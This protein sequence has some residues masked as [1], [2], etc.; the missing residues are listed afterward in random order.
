MLGYCPESHDKGRDEV[1]CLV[2]HV[3]VIGGCQ[4]SINENRDDWGLARI[5]AQMPFCLPNRTKS[6]E[7]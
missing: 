2:E 7:G 4:V 5:S 1:F 3:S 6:A